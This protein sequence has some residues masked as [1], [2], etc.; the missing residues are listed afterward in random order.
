MSGLYNTLSN[1]VKA[2]SAHSR[3]IETAGR[4]LAN[5]NNTSY[6][7]QRVIYGEGATVQTPDGTQSMGLEALSIQQ[8]RDGLL[9][10]Q[11]MREIALKSGFESEQT[12]YQRAQ[13]ALGQSIDL[14]AT[15]GTTTDTSTGGLAASLDDFFNAFQSFA[16]RPTDTGERQLLLQ[17][18]A[19]LTDRFQLTDTRLGQ[20]QTDLDAQVTSDVSDVNRLLKTIADLNSQIGSLEISRPGSAVDLRDQRQARL[21]ELAAKLP[22]ETSENSSGQLE[23]FARDASNNPVTLVSLGTVAASVA[24]DGNAISA[25]SPPVA[26]NLS[27]GS[28]NGALTARTGAVQSLRSSLDALAKQLVTSVNAAYNPTGSTGDF[29][30]PS[31]TTAGGISLASGLNATN[32]KASDGGASGDNSIALAVAA[33]SQQQF[34]TSAGDAIDG[35]FSEHYTGCV[36]ELGQSLA[37]ANARVSDQTNIEQLVRSQRDT[38]SGVSLDEE[39]ADLVRFQRAY[40]ASSRVFSI[41]DTLLD[42][43]VNQLG[44]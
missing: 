24:Y 19:I 7:R 35:T 25:G 4:N 22:V 28:I 33:L 8:M 44:R 6:A 34:S 17:K 26:L 20:V 3:A 15:S 12:G 39:M 40:Q 38:V 41:V 18:A 30:D 43:V 1:S 21:E 31:G 10:R 14:S 2:L 27:S 42:N 11:V 13:A 5:V 37:S 29:F 23:V 32:L 16:T 9:D 36:T